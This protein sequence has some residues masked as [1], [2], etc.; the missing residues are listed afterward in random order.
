MSEP[1]SLDEET[2]QLLAAILE[3]AALVRRDEPRPQQ[4]DAGVGLGRAMGKH[5]LTARHASALL[6]I[7]L[8][9]PMSVTQLADRHHVAVKTASLVA[10]ELEQAGLVERR[11]DATDR[12][13][14]ILVLAR[15]KK[16]LIAAGLTTRAAPVQRTLLQLN[17]PQR[18]NLITGLAI[19]VREMSGF[20]QEGARDNDTDQA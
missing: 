2:K 14:T 5:G 3:F 18:Q 12:R 4:R 10:V 8:W 15:R 13:R 1:G 16:R 20:S 9:G 19:L 6:T 17:R 7:A 11:Q